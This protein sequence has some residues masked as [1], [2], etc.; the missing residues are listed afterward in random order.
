MEYRL[1]YKARC[2]KC[3]QILGTVTETQSH[4]TNK[5][6]VDF[7]PFK[8]T[9]RTHTD[10]VVVLCPNCDEQIDITKNK[11]RIGQLSLL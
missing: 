4:I 1:D 5:R 3:E 10:G 2:N 8:P 6:K 9:Q 11:N 7:M